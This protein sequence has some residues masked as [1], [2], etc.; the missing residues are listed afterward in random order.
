M[1]DAEAGSELMF[2]LGIMGDHTVFI[3]NAFV[4]TEKQAIMGAQFYQGLFQRMTE[5]A[6]SES[7][8]QPMRSELTQG[9]SG[10]IDFLTDLIKGLLTGSLLMNMTP[11]FVSHMLDEALEFEKF[12]STTPLLFEQAPRALYLAQ[13][14]GIWLADAAGHAAAIASN[15]DANEALLI[16]EANQY[17][18]VFN[19][20]AQKAVELEPMIK[21]TGASNGALALLSQQATDC[22]I[23]FLAYLQKIKELR[24]G[25]KAMAMGT[26]T[27]LV[28][29]HMAR[30]A[31]HYLAI[32]RQGS[33]A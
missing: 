1:A 14:H 8:G 22:M 20:L 30:E 10:F 32:I 33:K 15:L 26:L 28:A 4:Y 18:E 23:R 24:A 16:G 19:L 5:R 9:L 11:S 3:Q 7:L 31:K 6:E 17:K 29:D 27:P 25:C 12:L 2:W 21:R 13:G